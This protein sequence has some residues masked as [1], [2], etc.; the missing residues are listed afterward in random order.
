MTMGTRA[1]DV[2]VSLI[3]YLMKKLDITDVDQMIDILNTESGLRG[4]SGISHDVRDLE[5]AAPT[6][7]RAKLALDIFVN[8]IIKYI[9]AY[10]ALMNGVDVL[11]FTAGIGEH[12]SNIRA[13]IMQSLGYLGARIDPERN[14]QIH[15]NAGD[16]T[17]TDARVKTLVIPTNEELMI[18]RDVMSL[19]QVA[20]QAE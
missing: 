1:G 2:D 20:Q 7:P 16:I 17:A 10:A 15:D 9:G 12:S 18:V 8:R 19:S 4:I 6:H 11:V 14:L 3:A 13:R 5:A